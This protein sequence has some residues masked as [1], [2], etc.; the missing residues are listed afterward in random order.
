[1]VQSSS[2]SDLSICIDSVSN[3][4][5]ISRIQNKSA[6]HVGMIFENTWLSCYPKPDRCIHDNGGEFIGAA[7]IHALK[8]NEVHDVPTM[9][10]NPQSNAICERMHQTVGNILCTLTHSNPP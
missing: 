1:M 6:A 2:G 7:F 9:I 10:K 4:L 5:D 8:T 3:L